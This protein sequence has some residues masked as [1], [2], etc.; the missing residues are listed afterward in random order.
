VLARLDDEVGMVQQRHVPVGEAG[1]G[2]L[3]E[4]HGRKAGIDARF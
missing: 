4:W 1:F 3:E 2:D